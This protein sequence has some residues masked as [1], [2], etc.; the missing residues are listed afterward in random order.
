MEGKRWEEGGSG[1]DEGRE[2]R[3]AGTRGGCDRVG[4]GAQNGGPVSRAVKRRGRGRAGPE[5]GAGTRWQGTGRS[6]GLWKGAG[7]R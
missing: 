6:R 1:G 5:G 7:A 3:R 4:G 2:G